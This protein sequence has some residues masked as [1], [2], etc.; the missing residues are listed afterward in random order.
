MLDPLLSLQILNISSNR[1][2]SLEGIH[3][4]SSLVSLDASSNLL[5]KLDGI[6]S[7]ASLQR[8][9]VAYNR[10]DTL[11]ALS[12]AAGFQ[13]TRSELAYLDLRGNRLGSF[14]D[15][16]ALRDLTGLRHL[17]LHQEP[18]HSNPVRGTHCCIDRPM[19]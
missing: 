7:L 4:A 13:T 12:R 16:A 1:L 14:R 15:V 2:T 5:T 10:I 9:V 11:T 18:T 17:H 6:S 8:L 3:T 19:Y